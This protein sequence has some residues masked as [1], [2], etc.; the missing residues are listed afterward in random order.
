MLR[1]LDILLTLL[2]VGLI[3]FNLTGWI[4]KRTRRLHLITLALTASSWGVLG[5][6]YGW[7]YCPLT[8]WHWN[9]K[10]Q[11]GEQH[12]PNSFI[13]YCLDK[14]TQRSWSPAVVDRIT[15]ISLLT[16]VAASLYVNLIAPAFRKK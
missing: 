12:L 14:I 9:I 13:K 1:L 5:I 7:G 8:D 10:Q 3:I 11:L 16:A 15:L 2:H 6:W 4:W